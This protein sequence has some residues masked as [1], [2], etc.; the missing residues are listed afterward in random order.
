MLR[1]LY[2]ATRTFLNISASH[3]PLSSL[4][5]NVPGYGLLPDTQNQSDLTLKSKSSQPSLPR[6]HIMGTG[7]CTGTAFWGKLQFPYPCI[8]GVFTMTISV[9]I[10][11]EAQCENCDHSL[12]VHMDTP[13]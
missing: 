3:P 13:G 5:V 7:L 9:L 4:P 1:L 6:F 12:G 11:N 10:I 2:L 8:Q